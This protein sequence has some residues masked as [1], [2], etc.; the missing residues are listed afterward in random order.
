M[1]N[2]SKYCAYKSISKED[3]AVLFK[4]IEQCKLKGDTKKITELNNKI[5]CSYI[6]YVIKHIAKYRSDKSLD[7]DDLLH[8]GILGLYHALNKYNYK[9]N[10]T[11]STYALPWVKFKIQLAL[12][13]HYTLDV[14]PHFMRKY[15]KEINKVSEQ[16]SPVSYVSLQKELGHD[17]DKQLCL[18]D[19]IVDTHSKN[20]ADTYEETDTRNHIEEAIRTLEGDEQLIARNRYGFNGDIKTLEEIGSMLNLSRVR[21]FAKEKDILKKL[22]YRVKLKA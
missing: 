5:V 21:I 9:R 7:Y 20:P 19:V 18:G 6:P 17:G 3:Q 14:T 16:H 4:E 15:K 11:F 8:E 1:I 10:Y 2:Y 22:S 12:R 13:N